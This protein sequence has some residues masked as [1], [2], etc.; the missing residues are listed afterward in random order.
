[1]RALQGIG[2]PLGMGEEVT[3]VLPDK[4]IELVG[5][6]VPRRTALIMLRV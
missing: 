6:A 5:G 1:M 2:N 3:H 4:G